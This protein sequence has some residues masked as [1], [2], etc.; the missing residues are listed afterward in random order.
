MARFPHHNLQAFTSTQRFTTG[1]VGQEMT[2]V[3]I[4]VFPPRLVRSSMKVSGQQI[5][6]LSDTK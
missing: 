5:S 4:L 1:T 2:F 3:L 6:W